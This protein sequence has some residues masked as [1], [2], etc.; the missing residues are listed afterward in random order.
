MNSI[1][2]GLKKKIEDKTLRI[3]VVG[4]GYVGLPLAVEFI[5]NGYDVIGIDADK[6]K[7]RLVNK[8]RLYIKDIDETYFR[9][10]TR[11]KKL[12]AASDYSIIKE[13]DCIS[14][15]V[16]TPLGKTKDPD[17][18]YVLNAAENIQKHLKKG[19]LV[20][21]ESTTYP[22]TTRELILPLFEKEN[23]KAGKDFF[24]AY[25]PE[26][27]D[28]GNKVFTIKNTPKILS[29]ITKKCRFIGK[30][31][32][33]HIID[34]VFEVSSTEAAEMV[35]LLENT[36]RIVNIALV[37]EV[38]LMCD[39]LNLNVWEIINAADTKPFGYMKFYPGPGLGGHCIPVDP[40]YLSWKLKSL[41]YRARFIELAAE[42]NSEMPRFVVDRIVKTLNKYKK[43]VNGSKILIIGVSY[44]KDVSDT[45]ESPALDILTI[46]DKGG[47]NVYYHD[48]LVAGFDFNG[49]RYKSRSLTK[50]FLGQLDCAVVVTDHSQIDYSFILNETA[51]IID[52]RNVYKDFKSN[53]I[54]TL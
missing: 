37:D 42:I 21:L 20:I 32:Y 36:F 26:R 41:D 29:G 46:L 24:L 25:S 51:I 17:I 18:S 33:S 7:V 14:I 27:I 53:K 28:P 34:K 49:K 54:V 45:R 8:G 2:N 48:P 23:L 11:S 16:P 9:R 22:G 13:V 38:A 40:L 30:Y 50:R 1:Y 47:A 6:N 5:K 35:K 10:I 12:Q 52:T 3:A 44:K 31:F 19:Q 15:C 39:R 4:L 43:S